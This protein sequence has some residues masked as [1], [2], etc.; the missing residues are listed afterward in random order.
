MT[1]L[2]A[3]VNDYLF[4]CRSFNNAVNSDYEHIALRV[5]DEHKESLIRAVFITETQMVQ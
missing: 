4:T 1:K 3:T 2:K 5:N